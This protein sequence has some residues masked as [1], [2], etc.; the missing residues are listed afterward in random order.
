MS[1][2]LF[3]T[4]LIQFFLIVLQ[5]SSQAQIHLSGPL[6]PEMTSL[7]FVG[8]RLTVMKPTVC[9]ISS[10]EVSRCRRKRGIEE[11]PHIIEFDNQKLSP[12]EVIR[13]KPTIA[14]QT[15]TP[16]YA[17]YSSFDD[18]YTL[19]WFRQLIVDERSITVGDCGQSTVNFSQFLTCLG[20]I[21][22][23]TKTVTATF[24]E[25]LTLSTGY[26]TI[27]ILWG[28][29][30]AS[31]PYVYCNDSDDSPVIDENFAVPTVISTEI[32]SVNNSLVPSSHLNSNDSNAGAIFSLV[33]VASENSTEQGLT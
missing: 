26:T 16:S 6:L 18:A 20:L 29:T 4:L 8:E 17:I 11:K 2:S 3:A 9:F 13:V 10:G 15:T 31:F 28:C 7:E 5:S 22:Q 25:T 21:V 1:F 23:Q 19:E 30:P 24:T 14:P 32:D 12:S 33:T 27:G